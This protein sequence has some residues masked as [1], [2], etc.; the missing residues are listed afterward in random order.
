LHRKP[1]GC[2]H[3]LVNK[4]ITQLAHVVGFAHRLNPPI[5]H[6]DLK[7]A[8]ILLE[9]L[10]TGSARLKV[11]DFGIG[12]VAASQ[13]IKEAAGKPE[14]FVT[15]MATGTCTPLYASPQQQAGRPADPRDDVF[16]LGIIWFQ[17]LTGNLSAGRPG[18]PA[19][20]RRLTEQGMTAPL[21]ELLE[22]CFDDDPDGRPRD[23][24]ELAERLK[25][26]TKPDSGSRPPD[27]SFEQDVKE[28]LEE[29]RAKGS[30]RA[31]FER[32]GQSRIGEWRAGAE[33]GNAQAQWLL[34]RCQHEGAG[35]QKDPQAAVGWIRRAADSGLA[36][37]QNDLGDC[38]DNGDGVGKDWPEAFRWYA[39]AAEQGFAEA[40]K[41][42]GVCHQY[43][44]GTA[45]DLAEAVRWYRT[46][47]EQGWADAMLYLGLCYDLGTGIE[48]DPAVG[49]SW[50]RKAADLGHPEG[51]NLLGECYVNGYGVPQDDAQAVSLYRKAAE[52]GL[53]KAMV[54]LGMC[55]ELGVGVEKNPAEAAM[56]YRKAADAGNPT[57]QDYLGLCYLNGY[58]VEQDYPQ[59]I[60]CFR[61]AAEQGLASAQANL[62]DCYSNGK[63]V[64]KNWGEAAKWYRMA[65]EQGSDEAQFALGNCYRD[66]KGV[67]EDLGQAEQWYRKAADQG[68]KKARNALKRL[69]PSD[70]DGGGKPS[71]PPDKLSAPQVRILAAL[72]KATTPLT[73]KEISEQAPA[74]LPMCNTY[75]GPVNEELRQTPPFARCLLNL[76]F[77][78]EAPAADGS[79]G[80]A[81]CITEAGRETLAAVSP[82]DDK[83]E[84]TF[85]DLLREA[86]INPSDVRLIRHKDKRAAPGR[87]PYDLWYNNRPQFEWYQSTQGFDQRAKLAAPYWAVF[88]GTPDGKTMFVGIYSVRYKGILDKDTPKPHRNEIDAAGSCDVYEPTLQPALGDLIGKMFIDWGPGALAWVQ[89]ADR[90]EKRIIGAGTTGAGDE[91]EDDPAEQ[92]RQGEA[93]LREAHRQAFNASS[94]K[95]SEVVNSIGMK[96]A[97]I[98]AGKFLMGSPADEAEREEGEHQ[99]EVEITRPFYMGAFP[100]TQEEF[101]RVMGSNPSKFKGSN[102]PVEQVTWHEAVE[103]CNRLSQLEGERSQGRVYRLPTEAEW[104]YACRAGASSYQTFH[105]GNALSS[106][107]ANFNGQ[108]PYGAREGV[109]REQ[110]TDVGSFEPNAWGLYD[111]HGNVWEWCADWFGE[112]YY[113]QS[114]RQDPPGPAQG[115]HRVLRGG[116]WYDDGL[117][118]RAAFR[119]GGDPGDRNDGSG[120]RVVLL[121]S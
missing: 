8:N 109:Y 67:E 23:A 69:L 35:T 74:D 60:G 85:N 70:E 1:G 103:F 15:A 114:N 112:N 7:P 68:H 5:V 116:S 80:S 2:P 25:A 111:M 19:W 17:A 104:E 77:V 75:I 31:Y 42:L 28:A 47:A 41:N 88:L 89:Y 83:P 87:T 105:C 24:A 61:K 27:L 71:G 4:I 11:A 53:P 118:C 81:Y 90:Q 106:E 113:K 120:F 9:R 10:A 119:V 93:K 48:K 16:A 82:G 52:Q 95:A 63:G 49:A 57:G 18:G 92:Q 86:G 56:F 99:H 44:E 46:A 108:S 117:G 33:R 54:N 64:K 34:A 94:G 30:T 21:V 110:T 13:A 100:V 73:R 97:R 37:A 84:R 50:Y 58:G 40:Q 102:R 66:G 72:A 12:G 65:A 51:E 14:R 121:V 91:Q 107:Q 79:R 39:K 43:G 6:R 36:I 76:G 3:A 20:R 26:L 96:L 29:W 38:Y 62:G 45:K 22:S 32:Q 101:Q 78:V 115:E 55:Y 98:P 59:A